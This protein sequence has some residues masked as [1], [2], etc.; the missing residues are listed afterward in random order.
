[1][2]KKFINITSYMENNYWSVD[3]IR[4][5][6][7]FFDKQTVLWQSGLEAPTIAEVYCYDIFKKAM[8][9]IDYV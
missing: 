3:D 5:L 8:K 6:K 2:S 7:E 4:A 1:M 9:D